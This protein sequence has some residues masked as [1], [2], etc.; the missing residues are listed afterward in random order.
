MTAVIIFPR[1]QLSDW[2]KDQAL[3]AGILV[4]EADEPHK[5]VQMLPASTMVNTDD[6]LMSAIHAV[7]HGNEG[8]LFVRQLHDRM[9]ARE[10]ERQPKPL[11]PPPG[12]G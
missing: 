3:A 11:P 2:D 5:V 9:I 4:M 1:G 6:M 7:R 8:Q 10:A 12:V